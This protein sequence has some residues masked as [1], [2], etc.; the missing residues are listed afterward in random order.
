MP[1]VPTA[2][3]K[4]STLPSVW[5]RSPRPVVSTWPSRLATLSNWLAQI[6]PFGSALGQSLGQPAGILHVIVGVL[7]GHRR[8]LDSSAPISAQRVLLLLAL[9][10]GD[11]DDRPVA[12]RV[13]DQR[14]AD[15]GI[16][17]GALDDDAAGPQQP[18][19]SASAMMNSAA[20]SLTDWPGFMNS[21]L[22]RI[23]QPVAS[24]ARSQRISGVL[25]MAARTSS[26]ICIVVTALRSN[27]AVGPGLRAGNGRVENL[28][29]VCAWNIARRKMRDDA[30]AEGKIARIGHVEPAQEFTGGEVPGEVEL[31]HR[32]AE[33]MQPPLDAGDCF[34]H[35][36]WRP[37]DELRRANCQFG[38]RPEPGK[39]KISP[40][41]GDPGKFP[42]VAPL[43]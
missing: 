20:R 1:P 19:A 21:A 2:Q 7:V 38:R 18:L 22:P 40:P 24:E 6:A 42:S 17:G 39:E 14:E 11:D 31:Q 30:D 37:P 10:L 41:R 32:G 33:R 26:L 15:A 29:L 23:S 9:G 27:H 16:A 35:S 8:H 25:P 5:P 4:P 36:H 34:P 3:T 13:G 43:V 12:Q 28:R